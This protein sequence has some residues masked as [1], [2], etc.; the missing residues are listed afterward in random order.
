M[1]GVLIVAR[2]RGREYGDK[3]RGLRLGRTGCELCAMYGKRGKAKE[4]VGGISSFCRLD[5]MSGPRIKRG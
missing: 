4:K 1:G 2:G 3:R 5:S